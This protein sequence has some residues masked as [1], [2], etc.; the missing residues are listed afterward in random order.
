M[1]DRRYAQDHQL[2]LMFYYDDAAKYNE[3][4]DDFAVEFNEI[5]YAG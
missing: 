5:S 1:I 4:F 2:L 3:K